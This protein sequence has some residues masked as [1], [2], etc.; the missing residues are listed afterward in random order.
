MFRLFKQETRTQCLKKHKKMDRQK[1]RERS[2]AKNMKERKN[3]S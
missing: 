1:E 3:V 2:H